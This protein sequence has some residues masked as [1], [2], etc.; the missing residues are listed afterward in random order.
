MFHSFSLDPIFLHG[1]ERITHNR[2]NWSSP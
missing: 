1:T 2:E